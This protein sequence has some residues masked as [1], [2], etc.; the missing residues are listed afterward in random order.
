MLQLLAEGKPQ[1]EVAKTL[2]VTPR[3]S[4]FHKYTITAQL[5][6]NNRAELVQY[7]VEHRLVTPRG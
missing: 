4:A 3:T 1:K 7:A 6:L 2:N 5:G